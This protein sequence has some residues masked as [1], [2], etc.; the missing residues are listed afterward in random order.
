VPT[1]SSLL[2][3]YSPG[4]M[5]VCGA[6]GSVVFKA[7]RYKSEGPGSIPCGV[8]GFFCDIS[9]SERSMALESTQ[10]LVKMSTRNIPGDKGGRCVRL[11]ISPPS[12]AECREISWNLLGNTGSVT[13]LL[14]I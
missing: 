7:L 14:Y 8:T 5:C 13:G 12:C 2:L 6:W 9:P 11:K 4:S 3:S 1:A 10:P